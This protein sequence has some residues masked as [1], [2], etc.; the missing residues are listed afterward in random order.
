M[1]V[2][3]NGIATDI[4]K[5]I[6]SQVL[7]SIGNLGAHLNGQP[8]DS[9]FLKLSAHRLSLSL[10]WLY[11]L[12]PLGQFRYRPN[13][14]GVLSAPRTQIRYGDVWIRILEK[15]VACTR[16]L[17]DWLAMELHAHHARLMLYR[18]PAGRV[19][20]QMLNTGLPLF[21]ANRINGSGRWQTSQLSNWP[22]ELRDFQRQ[23]KL[24][25]NFIR[26]A[27][28]ARLLSN[29]ITET[30]SSSWLR[31]DGNP[32]SP[33][34]AQAM[35][36]LQTLDRPYQYLVQGLKSAWSSTQN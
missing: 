4:A 14:K 11:A 34:W 26:Q 12:R 21:P 2:L 7:E 36:G 22:E 18:G 13:S 15:G 9:Q 8:S 17:P 19:K 3:G 1:A 29:G 20:T 24:R 27:C 10:T 35:G 6:E 16:P 32:D 31:H 28:Q 5:R 33:D 25:N 23:H 30:E